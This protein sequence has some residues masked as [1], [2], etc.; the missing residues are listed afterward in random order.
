MNTEIFVLGFLN[1]RALHGY[2]IQQYLQVTYADYWADILPGSIY[3]ALKKMTKKGWVEVART[4]ATGHRHRAIY[5]IT[6]A[7]KEALRAL[8]LEA[9]H[10]RPR[11]MPGTLYTALM[12]MDE[13]EKQVVLEAVEQQISALEN[14]LLENDRGERVK[15]ESPDAPP[16]IQIVMANSRAHL[17]ADLEMLKQLKNLLPELPAMPVV[18]PPLDELKADD[19]SSKRRWHKEK[20]AEEKGNRET[21]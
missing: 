14:E 1:V 3:N 6:P 19:E 11:T 8:L 13:L 10:K 2:D 15:M 18:L 9:W 5:K 7:G 21:A 4:E 17:Q 20:A 12:F 16:Y